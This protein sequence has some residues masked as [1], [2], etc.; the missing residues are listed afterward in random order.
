MSHTIKL[1][2]VS[3]NVEKVECD[4]LGNDAGLNVT[5]SSS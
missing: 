3:D 1:I 5:S 2:G 4:G